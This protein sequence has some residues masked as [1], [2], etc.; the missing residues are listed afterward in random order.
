[1]RAVGMFRGLTA[2]VIAFLL[3]LPAPVSAQRDDSR[4]RRDGGHVAGVFDHYVLALSWSPTHCAEADPRE[5]NDPQCAP[6]PPRPYAFVL[7]GLWPQY[8]QG[9]PEFCR[10]AERPFV[11]ERLIG[12]MLD[13]MP[14]R[15]LVIHQY[16]KHGTCSGLSPQAYFDLSRR[17]FETVK[18]PE[19][20]V[21]PAAPFTIG[22]NEVIDAFKEANPKLAR[23]MIAV[24][25]G[26]SGPRLQEVRICFSRDGEPRS[27]G[28]SLDQR[29]LCRADRL[30]VPPVR[31]GDGA[32]GGAAAPTAPQP[33]PPG[34][35]PGDGRRL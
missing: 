17:I 21:R 23:D 20:F 5:S 6:R 22:R 31:G 9:W 12:D 28:A 24:T 7:H 11:P 34:L 25:C 4:S 15:K 3:V 10:I 29:R 35:M 27:C 18:I 2:A 14:S 32:S 16:R 1:M 33:L 19:R 30:F 26:G 13:I 8:E